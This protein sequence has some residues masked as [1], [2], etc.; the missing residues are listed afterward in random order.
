VYKQQ[1][2][3]EQQEQQQDAENPFFRSAFLADKKKIKLREM[4]NKLILS[5]VLGS[6]ASLPQRLASRHCPL[7][8][9]G[10]Q[11]QGPVRCQ[12]SRLPHRNSHVGPARDI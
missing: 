9:R 5:N 6:S 12:L 4:S 11:L 10:R 8:Q 7:Q 1:Q 2:E 3:Q